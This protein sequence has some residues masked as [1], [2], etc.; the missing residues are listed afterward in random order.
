M[1]MSNRN[2]KDR[3]LVLCI[4][5]SLTPR[6]LAA[7]LLTIGVSSPTRPANM[8]LMS[9]C[10]EDEAFPYEAAKSAQED[11]REVNQSPEE[12]LWTKGR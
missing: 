10:T 12:S 5:S 7:A 3:A 6:A 11:V 2:K 4:G 9:V 1:L 8:P